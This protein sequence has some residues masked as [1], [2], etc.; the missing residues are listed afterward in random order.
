LL[1]L[2]VLGAGVGAGA[3]AVF[4][5]GYETQASVLLQ[6]ARQPDELL[7]QAQVATSSVVLSRTS[8]A[9]GLGVSGTD[10]Q[11]SVR[12]S[13]AQGNVVTITAAGDT[14]EHAQQLADEAAKEFVRYATQLLGNSADQA[15]QL[16]QQQK[17]AL[18]QQVAQT[19]QRILALTS[20]VP[21]GDS[22][23]G[24]QARTELQ[25]LRT[26]LEQAVNS[27]NTADAATG[28]GNMVVLGPS[29]RPSAESA[30]TLLQLT[31]GG[32]IVFFL[33]GVLTYL[34]AARTDRRPRS[35]SEISA[36][37]G[38]AVLASIDV[39]ARGSAAGATKWWRKLLGNDRPWDLPEVPAAGDGAA[40]EIRYR[41]VLARLGADHDGVLRLL[42]LTPH[43]DVAAAEVAERFAAVAE[44]ERIQAELT[45]AE[46]HLAQAAR[47]IVPDGTEWVLVVATLGAHAAWEWF[48]IAEACADAGHQIL[49]AV[50]ARE[51]RVAGRTASTGRVGALA[52]AR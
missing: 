13:V 28:A 20:S 32:A 29:E 30:P 37:L 33:L 41:R 35:E 10:L 9:L 17:E 47:P 24:V 49:G 22:V 11:K 43:G 27:L 25:G 40:R 26:A 48:S 38:A 31:L 5:P 1:L 52:G 16:A 8:A 4:S 50:L 44:A 39:P 3:S 6:G 15:A 34:F 2:A 45:V 42:V 7:T 18:R 36:A 23:E 46:V 12:A 21:N 19:N 14:P 51:V